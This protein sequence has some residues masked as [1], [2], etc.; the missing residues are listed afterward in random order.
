MSESTYR[1]Q[2]VS[3]EKLFERDA[4]ENVRSNWRVN[5]IITSG[6]Q[7]RRGL[8]AARWL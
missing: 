6:Q 5:E 7:Q 1:L 2:M 4:A 8:Q 3:S